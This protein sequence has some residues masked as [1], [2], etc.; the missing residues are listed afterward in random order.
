[1][2][3]RKT[4]NRIGV[5]SIVKKPASTVNLLNLQRELVRASDP[6]SAR[7]LAL[8]FK[9]GKG[10]YGEGDEFCGITVPVLRKIAK[11]YLHLRLADVKKLLVSR[12]RELRCDMRSNA[13]PNLNERRSSKESSTKP[14]E[15]SLWLRSPHDI[16]H[17]LT[18]TQ[19]QSAARP[20]LDWLG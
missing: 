15:R 6:Q 17:R 13:F 12:I 10:E 5:R 4:V 2:G 9:T 8:F 3:V 11:R 18:D 1:V 7:D 16:E 14:Q 19:P 20:C